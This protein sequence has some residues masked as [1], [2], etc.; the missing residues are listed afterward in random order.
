[1]AFVKLSTVEFGYKDHQPPILSIPH[2]EIEKGEKVFLFGPSGS[3]KTTLL[4]ILAGVLTPQKGTVQISG[5]NL[6]EL[7]GSARDRFRSEKMSYIFQSFN[8]L[9]YLS[10]KENILLPL[11]LSKKTDEGTEGRFQHLVRTL[12]IESVISSPVT[13]MSVGQQQRVAVARALMSSPE[14]ILADEPTSALDY[15]ARERFL[16]VLFDLCEEKNVTLVFVSH[17]RS[18]QKMFSRTVDLLEINKAGG[19]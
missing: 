2:L 8:L 6:V 3:G 19:R 4:E 7:S 13:E 1:M 9:P 16:K 11:R 12:G 14:I 15:D 17:D 10:A 5:Q 18:L